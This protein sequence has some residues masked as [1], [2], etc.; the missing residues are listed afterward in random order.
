MIR[1]GDDVVTGATE[2]VARH[3][4]RAYDALQL[5]SALVVRRTLDGLDGFVA[6]DTGLRAAAA[7]EGLVVLPEAT[8]R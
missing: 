1:V 6:F 2:A 3:P 5:A 4:L 8:N 7:A